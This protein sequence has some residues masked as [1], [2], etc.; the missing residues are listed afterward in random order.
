MGIPGQGHPE[1]SDDE[2]GWLPSILNQAKIR[3]L[4]LAGCNLCKIMSN[5]LRL[6]LLNERAV[7]ELGSFKL[8]RAR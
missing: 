6:E 8:V 5:A 3:E 1:N 2:R 4:T 7:R